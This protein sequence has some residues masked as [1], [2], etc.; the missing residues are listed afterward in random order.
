VDPVP[1]SPWETDERESYRGRFGEDVDAYER[2]RPVAPDNVFADIMRLAGLQ[3]GSDVLEIGPG[4]GQ[5]TRQLAR[6]G[7]RVLAVEIDGRLAER[8]CANVADFANVEIVESSFEAFEAAGRIWDAVVA[9]NSFHWVDPRVRFAKVADVLRPDGY[10]AILSTPVVVPADAS[11]FWWDLQDDWG[12]VGAGRV[13][14]RSKRPDLVDDFASAV[15]SCGYFEE[16]VTVRRPFAATQSA[17][18]YVASLSTQ[19]GFKELGSDAGAELLLRVERRI[20]AS[21]GALTVHRLAVLTVA[22]RVASRPGRST[23]AHV[24]I[25][26]GPCT[27]RRQ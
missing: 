17:Q 12:A 7:L 23:H 2:T 24:P 18:D 22:R 11:R 20:A 3:P 4:T 13:D 21:G 15:R 1:G 14:P 8:S 10:L 6:R 16:P 9:C 5:A 27:P 25:G 19:S 26:C